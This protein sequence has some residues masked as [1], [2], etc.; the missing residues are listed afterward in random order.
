MT[1]DTG[2]PAAWYQGMWEPTADWARA[3]SHIHLVLPEHRTWARNRVN[4]GTALDEPRL[5]DYHA[6]RHGVEAVLVVAVG[7]ENNAWL[8]EAVDYAWCRPLAAISPAGLSVAALDAL[9]QQFDSGRS[10]GGGGLAGIALSTEGGAAALEAVDPTVW[11]W[12]VQRRWLVSQNNR[13]TGWLGWLPVLRG[14][15]ALRLLVAHCGL[16]E[17]CPA[18][19]RDQPSTS[20]VAERRLAVRSIAPLLSYAPEIAPLWH[21]NSACRQPVLDC[22]SPPVVPGAMT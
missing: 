2:S 19:E 3:D 11:G 20:D 6:R 1:T 15:P 12:L 21:H 18:S 16:P 4:E 17:Q 13:G 22:I 5:Y 10:G 14:A 7:A 8:A 9:E